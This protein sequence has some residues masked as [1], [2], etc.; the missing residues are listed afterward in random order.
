[1]NW[2]KKHT[3]ITQ[4][5][6]MVF[7]TIILLFNVVFPPK[8]QASIIPSASEVA[9]FVA[10]LALDFVRFLGDIVE[11]MMQYFFIGRI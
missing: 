5:I 6:I 8:V 10:G 9:G 7:T 2:F 11:G 1:M 4:K 3:K